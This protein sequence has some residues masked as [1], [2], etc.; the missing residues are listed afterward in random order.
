MFALGQDETTTPTVGLT[1][2]QAGLV[3]GYSTQTL[4][5]GSIAVF[6]LI[7]WFLIKE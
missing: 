3:A 6:G 1:V 5:L 4:I 2:D 7:Y